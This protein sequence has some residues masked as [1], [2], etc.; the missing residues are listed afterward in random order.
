MF[1]RQRLFL[2]K[3]WKA[4]EPKPVQFEVGDIVRLK[5]GGQPMTVEG[6]DADYVECVWHEKVKGK[7]ETSRDRF[8]AATLEKAAKPGIGVIRVGRA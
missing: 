4:M 3:L 6:I 5:S 7:T 1:D 8:S 2:S